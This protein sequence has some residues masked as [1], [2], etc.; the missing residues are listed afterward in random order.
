MNQIKVEDMADFLEWIGQNHA[1]NIS[2]LAKKIGMSRM[3]L[4]NVFRAPTDPKLSTVLKICAALGI[5]LFAVAPPADEVP[6][7]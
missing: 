5:E 2:S 7:E 1:K 4:Y 6:E 3:A